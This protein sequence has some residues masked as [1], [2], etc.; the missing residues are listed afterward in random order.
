MSNY[1]S[2]VFRDK[3]V[4]FH[5]G[6]PA[7]PSTGGVVPVNTVIYVKRAI[8]ILFCTTS[9]PAD[10]LQTERLNGFPS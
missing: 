1:E 2:D 7:R 6:A 8:P 4:V 3:K 10:L 5:R 9:T